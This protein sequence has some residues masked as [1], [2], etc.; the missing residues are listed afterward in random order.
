MTTLESLISGPATAG[1]WNLVPDRSSVTFTNRSMWGLVNVKGTFTEFSGDGQITAKGAVFGRLDIRAA[2][3]ETGIGM[4]DRHL[5]SPD[6]FDVEHFPDISVVVTAVE[7]TAGNEAELRA[8]LAVRGN[9]LPIPLSATV[10][11]LE[12]GMVRVNAQATIDRSK[13]GVTGNQLGMISMTTKLTADAV[14]ARA[15]Q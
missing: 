2:S 11:P 7:P 8:T 14:F 13:W 4:R 5:R 6:F 1:V 15:E 10:N 3:L 9:T 12:D